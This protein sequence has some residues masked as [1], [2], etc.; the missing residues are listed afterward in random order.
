MA[1]RSTKAF[2]SGDALFAFNAD[3]TIVSWNR[4]AEALTGVLPKQR[5]DAVAGTC[6]AATTGVA[7]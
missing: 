6:S 4:A 1:E 5:S 7:T 2:R 3:L